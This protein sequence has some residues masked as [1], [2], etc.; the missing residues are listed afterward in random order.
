MKNYT[1]PLDSNSHPPGLLN[2][3]T[4]LRIGSE[5]MHD[6]ETMCLLFPR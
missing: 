4:G 5:Q 3:L 1:V 6:Y 2:V